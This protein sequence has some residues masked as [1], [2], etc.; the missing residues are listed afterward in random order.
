MSKFAV[1]IAACALCGAIPA[2]HAEPASGPQSQS[3]I[4]QSVKGRTTCL[5]G[6]GSLSCVTIDGH[7]ECR[8][9]EDMAPEAGAV[10]DDL[11]KDDDPLVLRQDG[12]LHIRA[13]GVDVRVN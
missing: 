13:G 10:P 9:D 7:T 6:S 8:R 3:L 5:Q 2:A 1:I 11:G 12:R 4:C